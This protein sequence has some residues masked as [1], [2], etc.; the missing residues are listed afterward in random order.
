MSLEDTAAADGR[1]A[2]L[3]PLTFVFARVENVGRRRHQPTASGHWSGG[4]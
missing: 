4:L 3:A 2:P 1:S